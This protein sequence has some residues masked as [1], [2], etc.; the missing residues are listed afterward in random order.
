MATAA[1]SPQTGPKGARRSR[2]GLL[3]SAVGLKLVIAVTGVVLSGFVLG[4]MVGNLKTFEGEEALNAYGEL[5][6]FEPALLWTARVVLLTAVGLHIW[7]YLQLY[8]SNWAAR[9]QRYKVKAHRESTLSSRSMWLTGPLVLGF[10]VYHILH[11]TTG[12]VHPSFVEG[13]VYHNVTAGL[14]VAPVAIFYV[15]AMAALGFHLWHGVYSLFTTLGASQPK[16]QRF[17]HSFAMGFTLIVVAGF[18][19]VPLSILAGLVK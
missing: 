17:G 2:L 19:A 4:H 3:T 12:T 9:S 7:A 6:H 5:L 1:L 16:L 8:R 10:I 13:D 11:L 18:A 15:L 14:S